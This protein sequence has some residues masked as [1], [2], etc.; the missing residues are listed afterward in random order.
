MKTTEEERRKANNEA[1]ARYRKKY[2]RRH[3]KAVQRWQKRNP[4]KV[5]MYQQSR[6]E[7]GKVKVHYQ[8]NRERL[9]KENAI[10]NQEIRLKVLN[11]YSKGNPRCQKCGFK[12]IECLDL[13]HI[14][15]GGN[16]DRRSNP[17]H[18]FYSWWKWIIDNNYPKEFQVLCRNCNW[19]K[20]ILTMRNRPYG[21]KRLNVKK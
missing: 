1:A 8:N 19:E 11:H 17:K 12:K 3:I 21:S 6:K 15:N 5:K 14:N 16:K 10:R 18:N 9:L 7:S 20:H 4:D 13:D 2:P